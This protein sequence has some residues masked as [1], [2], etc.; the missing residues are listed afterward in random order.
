MTI[1]NFVRKEEN[2]HFLSISHSVFSPIKYNFHTVPTFNNP[3]ID[4]FLKH[5]LK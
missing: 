1:E 4:S 3:A 2:A 5:C